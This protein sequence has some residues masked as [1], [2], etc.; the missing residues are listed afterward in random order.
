[1]D[2][3]VREIWAL[4]RRMKVGA[5]GYCYVWLELFMKNGICFAIRKF[6]D[7]PQMRI[8]YMNCVR[9]VAHLQLDPSTV[10]WG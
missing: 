7:I 1:M 4:L 8:L 10:E 9:C 6:S 2:V 5:L 3:I